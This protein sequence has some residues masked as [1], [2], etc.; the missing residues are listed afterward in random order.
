[1]QYD[2][3]GAWQNPDISFDKPFEKPQ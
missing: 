1:V 2:V 3:K